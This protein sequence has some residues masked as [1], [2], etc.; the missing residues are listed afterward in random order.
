METLGTGMGPGGTWSSVH[1]STGAGGPPMD[2]IVRRFLPVGDPKESP[3]AFHFPW[4]RLSDSVSNVHI[5][6]PCSVH[7]Y[8]SR[9][10]LNTHRH[11][12]PHRKGDQ[13]H[14]RQHCIQIT[15]MLPVSR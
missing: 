5:S 6:K 3:E 10:S 9:S 12:L 11:P 4:I 8:S 2:E 1:L 7:C 14:I 15:E 13:Q